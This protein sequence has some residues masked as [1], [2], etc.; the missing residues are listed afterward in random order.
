MPVPIPSPTEDG[1]R[2][3]DY[4]TIDE[5]AEVLG[6]SPTTIRRS[7]SDRLDDPWPCIRW[8][9]KRVLFS[10]DHVREIL[11]RLGVDG[12]PPGMA[13]EVPHAP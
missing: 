4:L 5:L 11:H 6:F 10:P 1:F 7:I 12:V 9:V 8:P 2:Y 3:V 13:S